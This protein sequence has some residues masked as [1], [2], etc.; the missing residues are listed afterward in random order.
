MNDYV[1]SYG[2]KNIQS[3]IKYTL[4]FNLV[5]KKKYFPSFNEGSEL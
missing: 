5:V 3:V 4:L 2:P 1:Y